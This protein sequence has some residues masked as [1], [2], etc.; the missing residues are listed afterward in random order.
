MSETIEPYAVNARHLDGSTK[1]G[2]GALYLNYNQQDKPIY[3]NGGNTAIHS[4]NIGTYLANKLTIEDAP[5][6]TD[7]NTITSSKI[8]GITYTEGTNQTNL[9]TP[10]G[11][12]TSGYSTVSY[13]NVETISFASG[14]RL[15]QVAWSCFSHNS[16]MW[17][18]TK[19]DAN[20]SPWKKILTEVDLSTID[21]NQIGTISELVK[22][23]TDYL[24][25]SGQTITKAEYSALVN[26]IYPFVNSTCVKTEYSYT[27][28]QSN[29]G[30]GE[31][32]FW[33]AL[34]SFMIMLGDSYYERFIILRFDLSTRQ[35]TKFAEV[36]TTSISLT[37][38]RT[39]LILDISGQFLIAR[40][41]GYSSSMNS[42]NYVYNTSGLALHISYLKSGTYTPPRR[43]MLT[44][45]YNLSN[46]T[47]YF[48]TS[49]YDWAYAQNG[50]HI[51]NPATFYSTQLSFDGNNSITSAAVT[52]TGLIVSHSTTG[53]SGRYYYNFYRYPYGSNSP[54]NI[55]PPINGMIFLF[56][57]L[58]VDLYMICTRHTDSLD[59]L[60]ELYVYNTATNAITQTINPKVALGTGNC[61]NIN[62]AITQ[63]NTIT[64]D[65]DKFVYY[66]ETTSTLQRIVGTNI[67]YCGL[68]TGVHANAI[69]KS[70]KYAL[71]ISYNETNL[72]ITLYDIDNIT[73]IEL[74]NEASKYIKFK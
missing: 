16:G 74:P 15:C 1:N 29:Y 28:P 69:D 53:S 26:K 8:V 22:P 44:C 61:N 50:G 55:T 37:N 6:N 63:S 27:L 66:G 9:H 38:A 71:G 32:I 14:Y 30:N 7:M 2:D 18:R 41:Y 39:Q 13:Y 65:T 5:Q 49:M 11:E 24:P 31:V 57:Y 56:P 20:W 3:M 70:Q 59:S 67:K 10:L 52:T 64:D 68:H 62:N 42:V 45:L 33:P 21:T 40:K 72:K 19:H 73:E 47:I 36:T 17:Y 12:T 60:H 51:S 46:N 48:F 54:T 58:A 4:G 35:I 23:S 43:D 34:N 25:L